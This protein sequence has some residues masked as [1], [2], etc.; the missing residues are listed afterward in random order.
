[1]ILTKPLMTIDIGN[2]RID[3]A[4]FESGHLRARFRLDHSN[5][6][7]YRTLIDKSGVSSLKN[8][9]YCSVVPI[10]SRK[11]VNELSKSHIESSPIASIS[12]KYRVSGT[13]KGLGEDRAVAIWEAIRSYNCPIIVID[14]GTAITVDLITDRGS[15]GGGMIIPGAK[16]WVEALSKGTAL[17]PSFQ[18]KI[19][20]KRVSLLG[21]STK[22]C[23]WAGMEHGLVLMLDGILDQIIKSCGK[24]PSI[25]LTGGDV[26]RVS[27]YLRHKH[28]VDDLLILRGLRE[29]F[30]RSGGRNEK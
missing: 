18:Y 2:N 22:K 17:I 3:N 15:F 19:E 30:Y 23:I 7:K 21:R 29:L 16:M 24:K 10:L 1:M 8:A 27:R 25:V 13:Y 28:F 11:V 9:V 26:E 4:I 20:R 6:P 5:I 14:L 12:S